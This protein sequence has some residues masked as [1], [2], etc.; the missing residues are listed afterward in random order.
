MLALYGSGRQA[1]ALQSYLDL[2]AALSDELGIDPQP[3]LAALYDSILHHDAQL[4][5]DHVGAA[6]TASPERSTSPNVSVG[7]MQPRGSLVNRAFETRLIDETLATHRLVTL[8]GAAGVGKT[9]MLLEV[10]GLIAPGAAMIVDLSGVTDDPVPHI[11]SALGLPA[12]SDAETLSDA[13][14]PTPKTLLIDGAERSLRDTAA[15]VAKLLSTCE[16]LRV[17]IAS[18]EP[19]GSATE[20]VVSLQPLD[21]TAARE[22]F[23]SRAQEIDPSFEP[24]EE[25]VG[26]IAKICASLD[27]LPLAIE[28]AAARTR[29]LSLTDIAESLGDSLDLLTE[30][31]GELDV[32]SAIAWSHE[33]LPHTEKVAFA[34]VAVLNGSFD[35]E[36]AKTILCPPLEE[37]QVPRILSRLTA[38]SLLQREAGANGR[39]RMLRP[40]RLFAERHTDDRGDADDRHA[41]HFLSLVEDTST[42]S[43]TLDEVQT[44]HTVLP[45]LTAALAHV[46]QQRPS[47]SNKESARSAVR[48]AK[49]ALAL[50]QF[51]VVAEMQGPMRQTR[52]ADALETFGVSLCKLHRTQ[53]GSLEYRRGQELLERAVNTG[54]SPDRYSALAGTWKPIDPSKA[55]MLYK[56][57]LQI[58]GSHPYA[59]GNALELAAAMEEAEEISNLRPSIEPALE[60][61]SSQASRGVNTP[62]CWYDY[63]KLNLVLSRTADAWRGYLAGARLS[64]G[65]FMLE[66]SMDS[67]N[68]LES[69]VDPVTAD[70]LRAAFQIVLAGKFPHYRR[71]LDIQ[72][73]GTQGAEPF[74]NR[75]L[76]L[77]GSSDPARMDVISIDRLTRAIRVAIAGQ[78][79][80]II[81]GGTEQGVG[82]I[83]SRIGLEASTAFVV[84]YLPAEFDHGREGTPGYAELRHTPGRDFG[85]AEVIQYW[86]DLLSYGI[87]PRSVRLLAIGGGPIAAIEY[88]LALTLGARVGVLGG[89]RGAQLLLSDPVWQTSRNLRVLQAT[90]ADVN[91]FLAA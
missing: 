30:D 21:E 36:T 23:I 58:D 14:G 5:T 80:T 20:T 76:I 6:R 68:R 2:R 41:A 29:T 13:I 47:S 50:G 37:T 77:A 85:P 51:E 91:A 7:I 88:R 32:A 22:L 89:G 43:S 15:I 42:A 48:A 86:A 71:L 35:L 55:L 24:M 49:L 34:R 83:A 65:S 73:F 52:D 40:L 69:I 78:P 27:G 54:P 59:L 82:L 67:L 46:R 10:A 64:V 12:G 38:R 84:G 8:T 79:A 9:R 87:E 4:R 57:A 3:E 72:L 33:D 28:L 18:R 25:D 62:W 56:E 19:L 31:G 53:P 63:G 17:V 66:T 74:G 81:S 70:Q 45:E 16:Q 90:A 44:L 26:S 11:A 1:E 60:V 75:V 39:Y 61:C